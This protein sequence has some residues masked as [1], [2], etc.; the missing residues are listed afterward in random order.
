MAGRIPHPG[1]PQGTGELPLRPTGQQS[2]PRAARNLHQKGATVVPSEE[3]HS[4]LRDVREG[5]PQRRTG[6][7]E[8]RQ[9]RSESTDASRRS[10]QRIPGSDQ[11]NHDGEE[12]LQRGFVRLL[13]R[14]F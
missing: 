7:Q 13:E 12:Q 1:L 9:E 3:Q 10:V 2:R 11:T 6:V 8:H 14:V 5:S 4:L